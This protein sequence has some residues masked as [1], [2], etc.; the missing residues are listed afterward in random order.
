M[1]KIIFVSTGRCGT[2]RITEILREKLPETYIIMH[3][4]PFSRLA[5]VIG[6][7]TFR[8]GMIDVLNH[9]LYTFITKKY[10]TNHAFIS[11]DPLTAMI[12][13]KAYV[14]SKDMCIVHIKRDASSFAKSMFAF[15][16][17]RLKSFIAHNFIP[18]WQPCIFPL[19]NLLNKNVLKKYEQVSIL[20][21]QFLE[22]RYAHNSNYRQVSMKD[23][24]ETNVL[25]SIINKFFD[26]QI[27][28]SKNE[29]GIK[30]N[31]SDKRH[32]RRIKYDN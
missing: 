19:E 1:K 27:S 24:F 5:N 16:R 12:I 2:N 32:A 3:Q 17:S 30:S 29:L 20:K 18:F 21:N 13:P 25:E 11:T 4:M 14:A 15:S 23:L 26:E 9:F 10:S 8:F 28:I 7:I 6:N 22:R 31:E